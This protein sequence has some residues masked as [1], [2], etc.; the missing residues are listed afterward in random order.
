MGEVALQMR[1][2]LL[3]QRIALCRPFSGASDGIGAAY[4][5]LI[6]S[7][8]L[9]KDESQAAIV[10]PLDELEQ[11]DNKGAYLWGTVGSGK[12][13][14]MDLLHTTS[15]PTGLRVHFHELM[16]SIHTGIHALQEA[17]PLV[18]VNLPGGRQVHRR[19]QVDRPLEIV[20]DQIGAPP[21]TWMCIDEMQVTDVADAMILQPLLEAFIGR[22]IRLVFTSNVPPVGLYSAPALAP[23]RRFF[24]PCIQLLETELM[25]CRVGNKQGLDY[26]TLEPGTRGDGLQLIKGIKKGEWYMERGTLEQQWEHEGSD[27]G[28]R[29][30]ELEY[31]RKV[32]VLSACLDDG[33]AAWLECDQVLTDRQGHTWGTPDFL[34]LSRTFETVYLNG[35][36]PFKIDELNEAVRAVVMIDTLYE[37]RARLLCSAECTLKQLFGTVAANEMCTLDQKLMFLRARSRLFEMTGGGPKSKG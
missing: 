5:R 28:L 14:L 21:G 23:T 6:N 18:T 13:M 2:V 32:N 22:G 11:S 26:R 34:A 24:E 10:E 25:V 8:S 29:L 3:E 4:N 12:S 9:M 17:Q 30:V 15:Q 31:G 27:T 7:G 20:A 16:E 37:A 1:R 33:N 35:L 36:R 19:K